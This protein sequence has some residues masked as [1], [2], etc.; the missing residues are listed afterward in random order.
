MRNVNSLQYYLINLPH[1]HTE[2]MGKKRAWRQMT[3]RTGMSVERLSCHT[4]TLT[5]AHAYTH[6][7]YYTTCSTRRKLLCF[8][9]VLPFQKASVYVYD[10]YHSTL[11]LFFFGNKNVINL[12]NSRG[13]STREKRHR[14]HKTL[15]KYIPSNNSF[16]VL[17]NKVDVVN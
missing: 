7:R 3:E 9:Q 15:K 12:F 17:H 5:R 14:L 1:E 16:H 2:T 6:L 11:K 13:N 10:R 4:N 8:S